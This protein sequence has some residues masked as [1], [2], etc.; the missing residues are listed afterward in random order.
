MGKSIS[1]RTRARAHFCA[2][3]GWTEKAEVVDYKATNSELG[4]LVL[5]NRLIKKLKPPGNAAL[6]RTNGHVYIRCRLD[7]PYPVLEVAE[8]P[9]PGHAVNIGPL[10][11]KAF[12]EELVGQLQ[13]LFGLRQCG[14]KLKLR[15]H[16]SAYGQMGRCMS[17][18][19]NDL[20]PNA[21]RRKLDE[22]LAL[23][24]GTR[25]AGDRLIEHLDEA[26]AAAS[27]EQKYER[28]AVLMRRRDRLAGV[29]GGLTGQLEAV[30]AGTRLV[31]AQHPVKPQWDAFWIVAGRVV[32]WGALPGED[33]LRRR[34]AAALAKARRPV[35]LKPPEV[36]EVRIVASW[37]A[38]HMPEELPLEDG[39]DVVGFAAAATGA[40]EPEA[41]SREAEL[42][43]A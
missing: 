38:S 18:C 26:M 12:A 36:D 32:D 41:A 43:P 14:R 17:P 16:P 34:T 30:H 13:S 33:Q 1:L 29:L 31:L 28:A 24:D 19:L 25:P 23:F 37:V 11:G 10:R 20:D 7:I 21:Y 39:V 9:A 42:A 15:E 4:A 5:E 40:A 27:A 2:P 8:S 6:K 35:P 22:A 3:A